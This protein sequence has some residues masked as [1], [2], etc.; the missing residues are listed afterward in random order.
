MTPLAS[1][2]VFILA[3]SQSLDLPGSCQWNEWY[4]L[5]WP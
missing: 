1:L 2:Q 4:S 3:S 5:S